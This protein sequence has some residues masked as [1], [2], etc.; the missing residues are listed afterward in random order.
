[1][2]VV[3]FTNTPSLAETYINNKPTGGGWIKSL[4]KAIQKKVELFVVF[5]HHE[6]LEPFK[7]GE[8]TY[9]PVKRKTGRFA[10]FK[11]RM[12]NTLEPAEDI[13][14]FLKII[15]S[16]KPDLI[17]IH[18]TEKQFGLI[19]E[20]IDVPTVVSIQGIVSVYAYKYYSGITFIDVLKY[21]KPADFIRFKSYI[22]LFKSFFG[23]A[24]REKKILKQTRKIIGRTSWDKRVSKILAPNATYFHNDE[25]L[26]DIFYKASWAYK[27]DDTLQLFTTTGPYLY[28]GLETI[29]YAAQLLDELNI[30]FKWKI[31]GISSET[32]V[33]QLAFRKIK[34]PI[35]KNIELLGSLNEDQ[36]IYHMLQTHIYI[37]ASHIENSPNNLCEA[38]ILGIPC[39]ATCAGGTATLMKDSEDGILIQDGDPYVLAG[40]IVELFNDPDKAKNYGQNARKKALLRHNPTKIADEL[41]AIYN[42]LASESI[43]NKNSSLLQAV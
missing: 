7:F 14:V 3:W 42:Q 31:A 4:E 17:H 36:L 22:Q 2:K 39:I 30:K 6:N 27:P 34:K 24:L 20:Y 5:Y 26:R 37:M 11:S 29:L 15:S 38:Q 10:E 43:K 1:M 23:I 18:G 41:I 8:T 21:S 33:A 13:P 12:F 40:A 32:K 28:K 9:I 35:S 25:I 16:I 19:Q